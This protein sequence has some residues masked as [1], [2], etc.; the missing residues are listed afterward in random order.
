MILSGC[1]VVTAEDGALVGVVFTDENGG[2][3]PGGGKIDKQNVFQ[4]YESDISLISA[5]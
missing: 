1:V 4:K 3:I 5:L 2:P